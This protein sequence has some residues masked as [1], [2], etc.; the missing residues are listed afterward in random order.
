MLVE[1]FL[2]SQGDDNFVAAIQERF[3]FRQV[4]T[5]AGVWL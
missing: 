5:S 4:Q 3:A 1:D 2:H